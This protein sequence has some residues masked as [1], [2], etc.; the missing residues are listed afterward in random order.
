M[1][2]LIFLDDDRIQHLILK[3]QL[4]LFASNWQFE[5]FSTPDAALVWLENNKTDL[6]LSDLNF[7]EESGWEI[8]SKIGLKSSAPIVFL[9][10]YM[11]REDLQKV[12]QFSS[13]IGLFEKPLSAE[14]WEQILELLA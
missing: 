3:K 12:S 14:K 8:I 5:S 6:V 11:T 4:G 9:T 7:E 1:P 2:Q 13:V 10:G